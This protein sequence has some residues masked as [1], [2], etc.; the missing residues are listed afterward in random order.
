MERMICA[1]VENGVE[2]LLRV[3]GTLRRKEYEVQDVSM[4]FLEQDNYSEIIIKLLENKKLNVDGAMNQMKK[5]VSVLDVNL[6]EEE[7]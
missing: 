6:I 5:I 7:N 2:S 4:R 1:T 3:V